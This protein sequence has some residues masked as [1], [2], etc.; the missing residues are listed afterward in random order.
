MRK[1]EID[2]KKATP[3]LDALVCGTNLQ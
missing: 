2:V 1:I 3:I